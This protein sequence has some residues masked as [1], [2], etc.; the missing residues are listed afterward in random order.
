[1][2]TDQNNAAEK[3]NP[4][5]E[6]F[7][8][9]V[10]AAQYDKKHSDC[11]FGVTVDG[12]KWL[13]TFE[14]VTRE[15]VL[16]LLGDEVGGMVPVTFEAE[17]DGEVELIAAFRVSAFAQAP[18]YDA[19]LHRVS[20][21]NDEDLNKLL[22]V[23]NFELDIKIEFPVG[24]ETISRGAYLILLKQAITNK[25]IMYDR[26][27][28]CLTRIRHA[29][30]QVSMFAGPYLEVYVD[31]WIA[32]GPGAAKGRMDL[33]MHED[34]FGQKE[35]VL[36]VATPEQIKS[37]TA[38]GREMIER[39]KGKEGVSYLTY[40]GVAYTPGFWGSRVRHNVKGRVVVDSM[41]CQIAN[42]NEFGALMRLAGVTV[43]HNND[44]E[45]VPVEARHLS[46]EVLGMVMSTVVTYD[47]TRSRWMV[48][49]ASN[50]APVE[51]RQDAF[52]QL[53][54]DP[55]RKRLV[56][57]I[58]SNL[59]QTNIDIID[60]KGGGAIFLLDG[61]P[62]TGKTLTAEA[63]AEHMQRILYKVSLGELGTEVEQLE[64]ALNRILAQATRWDA[65]LLIDEA[66]VFLEKRS[67]ENIQ[68]NAMVAVFLRLLEYYSGILFLT[69]N[70][71]NNFDPA[72]RSRVTLAMH[73]KRPCTEG[74][75]R[76]WIN[77]LR[78]AEI[79]VSAEELDRLIDFKVN[80]REIKNAIN[81]SRA[82]AASDG[83]PVSIDHLVEILEI[84]KLFDQE[85][86]SAER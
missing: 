24:E 37:L 14:R 43:E 44:D 33:R 67:S 57:A 38:R 72:L 84:Q 71:G 59:S 53:V 30:F 7:Q 78:N 70:R 8:G 9:I 21:H 86:V 34:R 69:T 54:L 82:L 20:V 64:D 5:V 63:S 80:G 41:G 1:M 74:L 49:S 81:S 35:M 83:V 58:A 26:E 29:T 51:F 48:G 60:G 40:T 85:V 13:L 4:L 42:P 27:H 56:K 46:E 25:T 62:G 19:L 11:L 73:Y 55:A 61:E 12:N 17:I 75:K 3:T 47:L 65:L 2:S 28:D 23:V 77:L 52:D 15:T 39:L 66:D 76:I 22:D 68:R 18:V 36:T 31:G 6:K 50:L 32:Y 79:R 16:R 10:A 45:I